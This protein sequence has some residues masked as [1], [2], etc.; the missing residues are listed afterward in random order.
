MTF[1]VSSRKSVLIVA[2]VLFV[3]AT[4]FL[5]LALF[6]NKR[7]EGYIDGVGIVD[8]ITTEWH[9]TLDDRYV[10]H[11]YFIKYTYEGVEYIN[12]LM[13]FAGSFNEGSE[14]QIL[15]NPNNPNIIRNLG[16]EQGSMNMIIGSIIVYGFG[17]VL[18]AIYAVMFFIDKKKA[19]QITQ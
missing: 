11:E 10:T 12:K 13:D 7:P 6:G 5:L 8:H 15:I 4:I 2:I 19:N 1:Q 18:G 17:A 16:T 14:V 3:A 9:G